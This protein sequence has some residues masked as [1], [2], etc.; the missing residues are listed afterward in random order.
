ME[1]VAW[2]STSEFQKKPPSAVFFKAFTGVFFILVFAFFRDFRR[3]LPFISNGF[4]FSEPNF[5]LGFRFV[6]LRE[7]EGD[8]FEGE[9]VAVPSLFV[10]RSFLFIVGD[11]FLF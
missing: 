7:D 1:R 2:G 9:D 10:S 5:I 3:R 8:G 11:V 4:R 6:G